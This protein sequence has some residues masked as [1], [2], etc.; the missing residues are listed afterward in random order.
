MT[1]STVRPPARALASTQP[2]TSRLSTDRLQV[3]FLQ[4]LVSIVLSYQILFSPAA[5]I[6]PEMQHVLI[7]GL[8]SLVAA[9]MFLP[10]TLVEGRAFTIVA[11]LVD[12][13]VTSAVIYL[14]GDTSSDLYLAYFFIILISAIGGS[15]QLK[16]GLSIGVSMVYGGILLYGLGHEQTLQE[17]HLIRIPIL[18]VMGLFYGVMNQTLREARR[19]KADLVEQIHERQEAERALIETEAR[20][21]TLIEAIPQQVWTAKPNGELD[22]INQRVA[23]YFGPSLQ[24]A[25]GWAWQ[26]F[27]HPAE[28]PECRRRWE[29]AQGM[30][31]PYE[32]ECR[33]KKASDGEYHW[34]IV[35]AIPLMDTNRRIMKWYGTNTDITDH[36]Q[37]E[38][39]VNRYTRTLE[40]KNR[41]L[42][43]ARD[44]A[45]SADRAKSEFLAIMS[46]EIRTPMNGVIGMTALLLDTELTE[47]Q[48][49]FADMVKNCG[50]HLLTVIN[51]ILD[52]SKIDAGKLTLEVMDFD[53][54]KAVE[55]TIG[56]LAGQAAGKALD[57][58]YQFHAQVPTALR[59]DPSRL[60]QILTNLVGNA[61]KFTEEGEVYLTVSL[62]KETADSVTLLFDVTDT[63]IGIPQHEIDRLFQPFTQADNSNKRKFGGTGLGLVISKRLT[64]MM[65]G[66]IGVKS[67]P[68]KGSTFQFTVQLLKQP[69]AADQVKVRPR[70]DMRG[71]RVC[72]VD[73]KEFSR[74]A[75]QDYL[76]SWGM[77]SLTA[78]STREALQ[79]L[80]EAEA[81]KEP[82]EIVL[83][84]L[85]MPGVDG[86][87]LARLIKEDRDLASTQ[88]VLLASVGGRGDAKAARE[89]GIAAYL[90]K[91]VRQ[92][93]LFD[94]FATLLGDSA[95]EAAAPDAAGA[96][97]S[98][99]NKPLVTKHSLVEARG[100]T[101]ARILIVE[102]NAV[103]QKV[104]A[105]M[106]EQLGY[107]VEVVGNGQE[108]LDA[109][110]RQSYSAVL[111]DCQMPEMDGF[112]AT[113]RI[114]ERSG[115]EDRV[116]VIAMTANA[117]QGD[118]ERCLGAG[119][120]DYI[121]KPI[122]KE[123]L[124]KI[125]R[126]W[127]G[128][129]LPLST[130]P[131]ATGELPSNQGRRT[132]EGVDGQ[133][134][135]DTE[136]T[137][138]RLDGD[139]DLLRQLAD[140]FV[141]QGPKEMREV[142]EALLQGDASRLVQAAH[143]LKGSVIQFSAPSVIAIV[144]ELDQLSRSGDLQAAASC[145]AKLQ[146]ELDQLRSV[147][148]QWCHGQKVG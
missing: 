13:S 12:T 134:I 56:L 115:P 127:V 128:Q 125:L 132:A 55:D 113:R 106:L 30:A 60:R 135:W 16:I 122:H 102:D 10:A 87:E 107:S 59:G 103:N 3:V 89:A 78:G 74:R 114:R 81:R 136:Q 116:V 50:D 143:K 129:G 44:Q 84:D 8:L 37:A 52:F 6:T 91:P 137:L 22:Y 145:F 47:E 18:L 131:S 71:V 83:L 144:K 146:P 29:E 63:G 80:R 139:Q 43:E 15:L 93:L 92:S 67:E 108:A 77:T 126:R 21:R 61:V 88:I 90:T 72:I 124:R 70:N 119:M 105:R 34:H 39:V 96:E 147:L 148:E 42:A 121:P 76:A 73:D 2:D 86:L 24:Q 23:D 46:H 31:S 138:A 99:A 82:C 62:V 25:R 1:F 141:T 142:Q 130:G 28:Q 117:M 109:L 111:M 69:R 36:K 66:A 53:L 57:L 11:L 95:V 17:G 100:G 79:V 9:S 140:L 38:E 41:E 68:G 118:R 64:E 14:S 32:M 49:T 4:S 54:R 120:D 97:A 5:L 58:S 123:E 45:L 65:G 19:E 33:L 101:R 112:E 27:I 20:F 7:L 94:C 26:P 75:M 133:D 104:A 35:R 110:S 51:D 85:Q 40:Q 48:R 98:R